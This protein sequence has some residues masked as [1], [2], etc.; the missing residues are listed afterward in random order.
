[1]PVLR[2]PAD[3]AGFIVPDDAP[4]EAPAEPS[5]EAEESFEDYESEA[6][7]SE[8]QSYALD[9]PNTPGY[10]SVD[11]NDSA[12][13][14]RDFIVNDSSPVSVGR[15]TQSDTES[16]FSCGSDTP[17][18]VGSPYAWERAVTDGTTVHLPLRRSTRRCNPPN[19]YQDDAYVALMTDDVSAEDMEEVFRE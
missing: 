6:S 1:M 3:L 13:S 2:V 7:S 18:S 10:V 17:S 12:G 19:R 15:A 8:D 11:E 16:E 5:P 4:E 14:L 9:E